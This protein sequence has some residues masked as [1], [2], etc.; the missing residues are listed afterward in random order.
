MGK[1]MTYLVFSVTDALLSKNKSFH[2]LRGTCSLL[3]SWD[4]SLQPLFGYSILGGGVLEHTALL[5]R[6]GCSRT[7][8]RNSWGQNI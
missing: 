5:W 3:F 8:F 4:K 7:A 1:M 2:S 6:D